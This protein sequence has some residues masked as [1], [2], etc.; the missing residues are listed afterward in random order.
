MVAPFARRMAPW[1]FVLPLL[2]LGCDRMG[3]TP[4]EPT[5]TATVKTAAVS[6]ADANGSSAA[7]DD[8]RDVPRAARRL[9]GSRN[10][11]EPN[12]TS[13][14]GAVAAAHGNGG[15]NGNG[16]GGGG[17]GGGNGGGGNGGGGNGHG[18][19]GH[20]GDLA[21]TISPSTWNTN[22][23]HAEGN[24]QAF[25]RGT[26]AGKIDRGSIVL[27]VDGGSD[28]LT[29]RSTRYAGGQVV[30]TFSK[31]DAFELLGD[32][33]P[34][35]RKT[36]ILRFTVGSG[37]DSTDKELTATVRIVGSDDGGGSG[38]GG[39]EGDL[40]LNI[41]PDDWNTNWQHSSG[42]VHAFI[43]GAGLD[44][45]DLSTIRLVGDKADAE[46]LEPLDARRVGKQIAVRFS[47]SAAYATL[48]DPHAGEKHT[49]KVTFKQDGKDVELSEDIHVVGRR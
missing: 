33:K 44:K 39:E 5:A 22:W 32:V 35:D 25:V 49:V 9:A 14:A 8:S 11:A 40:S 34:G 43:R 23:D 13:P 36:V 24:V 30:A 19:G 15:G 10:D 29:P 2:A 31:S 4:T 48:D 46:P 37:A 18:G 27:A 7:L 41:Q 16:H 38:S 17:N 21:F 3:S 20:G 12:T 26:D 45:V 42:Q 1:L 47:M 28:T 6:T